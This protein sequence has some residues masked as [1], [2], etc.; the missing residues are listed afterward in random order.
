MDSKEGSDQPMLIKR[1]ALPDFIVDRVIPD[2]F[3]AGHLLKDLRLAET[4]QGVGQ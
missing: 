1:G 3:K 2:N 4:G